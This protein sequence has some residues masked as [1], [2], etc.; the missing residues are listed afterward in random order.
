MTTITI[1]INGIITVQVVNNGQLTEGMRM[2]KEK[3]K[4]A[5]MIDSAI[6]ALKQAKASIVLKNDALAKTNLHDASEIIKKIKEE[7]GRQ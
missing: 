7:I 6:D 2:D 4:R 3:K 1:L 5:Y